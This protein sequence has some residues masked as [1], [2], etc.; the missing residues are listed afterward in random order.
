[1]AVVMGLFVY[2]WTADWVQVGYYENMVNYI[3]RKMQQLAKPKGKKQVG[4][5]PDPMAPV[6]NNH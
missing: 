4:C 5:N 2:I 3:R 6:H 1:M